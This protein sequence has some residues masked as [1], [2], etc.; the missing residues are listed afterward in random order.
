MKATI[1][2]NLLGEPVI[3][4]V[5]K[6]VGNSCDIAID[7][8][9]GIIRNVYLD[10]DGAPLYTIQGILV[11]QDEQHRGRL[12]DHYAHELTFER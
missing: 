11:N 1:Q 2:T 12:S 10:S 3:V 5:R 7:T 4:T 8:W 9:K 6:W